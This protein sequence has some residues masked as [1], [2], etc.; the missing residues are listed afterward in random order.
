MPTG[1]WQSEARGQKVGG[2]SI[3]RNRCPFPPTPEIVGLILQL[4]NLWIY[5]AHRNNPPHILGCSYLLRWATFCLWSV[6]LSHYT[7]FHFTVACCSWILSLVKPVAL[8]WPPIPGTHL[9]PETWL[10]SHAPFS[11][12]LFTKEIN[13]CT[14]CL[15]LCLSLNSFCAKT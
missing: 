8:T 13:K 2:G 10:A 11:C 15:S 14:S 12:N 4:F 7:C 1:T 9:R 3:P 5:P 6:Y